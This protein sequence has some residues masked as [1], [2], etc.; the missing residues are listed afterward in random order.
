MAKDFS[1]MS[2]ISFYTKKNL[3]RNKI[4]KTYLKATAITII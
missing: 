4:K 3:Q 2:L 1:E